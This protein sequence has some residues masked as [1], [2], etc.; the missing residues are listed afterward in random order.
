MRRSDDGMAA[1]ESAIESSPGR[2]APCGTIATPDAGAATGLPFDWRGWIAL[3]WAI[4]TGVMY[5]QMVARSRFPGLWD[6][7]RRAF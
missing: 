6:A 5:A 1:R 4:V 2:D 7:I 3:G